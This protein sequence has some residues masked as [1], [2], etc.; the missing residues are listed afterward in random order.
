MQSGKESVAKPAAATKAAAS[1]ASSGSNTGLILGGL[2]VAAVVG[3][4]VAAPKDKA[5]GKSISCS[6]MQLVLECIFL[7]SKNG[8]EA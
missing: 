4:A 2:A 7:T 3:V 8:H 1:K 5:G 6:N